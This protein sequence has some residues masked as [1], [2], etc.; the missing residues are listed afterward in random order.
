MPAVAE[1]DIVR[2]ERRDTM[3]NYGPLRRVS[4]IAELK[5]RGVG[6]GSG[7]ADYRHDGRRVKIY[8]P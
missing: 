4:D 7:S 8:R 1:E 3:F 6:P 5:R 2:H